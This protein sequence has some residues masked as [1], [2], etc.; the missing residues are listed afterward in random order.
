MNANRPAKTR[1]PRVALPTI[2]IYVEADAAGEWYDSATARVVRQTLA[3]TCGA[4]IDM[5]NAGDWTAADE[6]ADVLRDFAEELA[7]NWR[8]QAEDLVPVEVRGWR[9][10]DIQDGERGSLFTLYRPDLRIRPGDPPAG[11]P[12]ME[13]PRTATVRPE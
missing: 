9:V 6:R 13:A 3:G 12:R 8:N 10:V 5:R 2:D 4:V 1:R 11:A 7:R